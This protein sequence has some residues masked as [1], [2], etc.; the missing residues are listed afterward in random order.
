EHIRQTGIDYTILRSA[1]VFGPNDG[2]TTGLARLLFALPNFFLIPGGGR[3]LLQPFWVEDLVTCLVWALDDEGT[4]NATYEIG[5]P[6][7]VSFRQVIGIITRQLG[8]NRTLIPIRPPY[9]RALTVVLESIFP[10]MPVS[11]FWL[12]YLATN[13][14][15]SLDTVPRSFGLLP[16]RFTQQLDYLSGPNWRRALWRSLVRRKS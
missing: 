2:F 6:E 4:R 3:T 11:V 1:L 7:Y 13:R 5:G 14:T 8:I 16:S 9:L 12:D 15:C 10:G